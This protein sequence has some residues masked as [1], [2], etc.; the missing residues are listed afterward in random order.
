MGMCSDPSRVFKGKKLAGHMGF[1]RV[2]I[3]NLEVVLVDK[4][5]N[6]VLVKGSVPG[7]KKGLVMLKESYK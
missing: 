5:N 2:T 1:E 6:L 4:E 7:P 3:K